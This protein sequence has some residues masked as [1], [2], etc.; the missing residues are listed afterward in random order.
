MNK[1]K[2]NDG[3]MIKEK[4]EAGCEGYQA[5]N[6]ENM[7]ASKKTRTPN[8]GYQP[9]KDKENNNLQKLPK[10]ILND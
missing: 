8:F 10:I 7:Q 2:I 9:K 4:F 3:Y 6:K 5:L 1:I